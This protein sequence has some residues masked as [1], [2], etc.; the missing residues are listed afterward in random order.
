MDFFSPTTDTHQVLL[1]SSRITIISPN[2][3]NKMWDTLEEADEF[4][5]NLEVYETSGWCPA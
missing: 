3:F 1:A 2:I 4:S 5:V